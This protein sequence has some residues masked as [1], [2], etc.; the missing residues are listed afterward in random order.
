MLL[1]PSKT[2]R[3]ATYVVAASNA[4]AHVKAQADYVCDGV[5]DQVEI[6]AAI[7][8]LPSTTLVNNGVVQ[9]SQGSFN[10]S[11]TI[12]INKSMT[13]TGM[14]LTSTIIQLAANTNKTMIQTSESVILYGVTIS[15]LYLNGWKANQTAGHGIYLQGASGS[16][17][18]RVQN[19]GILNT[20][21]SGI[22]TKIQSSWILDN[23]INACGAQGIAV[24]T[25]AY[26]TM[27]RGNYVQSCRTEGIYS[28]SSETKIISNEVWDCTNRG[29]YLYL[30]TKIE[31]I[32]NDFG[33]NG[34]YGIG[35]GGGD[36]HT[37]I[38]NIIYNN[39]KTSAGTYSGIN[40]STA[41]GDT[42]DNMIIQGNEIYDDQTTKTQGYGINI[43]S[44]DNITI[45]GNNLQP[46]KTGGIYIAGGM[47]LNGI[48]RGNIGY[49]TENSGTATVLNATTSIVVSH[50]LATTPTRVQVTPT[51][52]PTNPVSFWWVDTLTTTQ[53]T[54]HVNANPG[55]SNLTFNWRAVSG[56]GN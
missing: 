44:G 40:L 54:I 15:N 8:A 32:G 56:E 36:S 11:N 53:F 47:N 43:N 35:I 1:P 33:T 4:P 5:N 39:S 41:S 6:Q 17:G 26:T 27:V 46:N 20:K 50:G 21:E 29:L 23:Y 48:V 16:F 9:L 55:A 14:G 19:V 2:G 3:T 12:S 10:I 52:N 28:G 24:S 13:L 18:A 7:D 34:L 31:V 49:K 42:P 45:I 37:I 51:S 30:A 25:Y 38:G 22:T